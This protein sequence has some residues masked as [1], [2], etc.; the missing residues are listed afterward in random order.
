PAGT[1]T[2]EE[3]TLSSAAVDL[4]T[5][6]GGYPDRARV[7]R[8]AEEQLVEQCMRDR[9]QVYWPVVPALLPGSDEERIVDL[10]TR[11]AEGYGLASDDRPPSVGPSEG[12]PEFQRALFG[13]DQRH[14]ELSLPNGTIL[15]YPTS[16][17]VA[18][19]RAA[20]FGDNR[21]WARVDAIP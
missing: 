4:A 18:D 2:G 7:L 10:P 21:S 19:A 14:E 15:S 11:Q 3:P 17:C 5:A 12:Q 13:D 6:S 9:G 8:A 16:G 20:I 1:E